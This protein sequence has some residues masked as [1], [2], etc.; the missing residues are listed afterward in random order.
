MTNNIMKAYKVTYFEMG[1]D[2]YGY[3]KAYR[4]EKYF[5]TEEKANAFAAENADAKVEEIEIQ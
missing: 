2:F 1:E 3:P 5:T 4:V